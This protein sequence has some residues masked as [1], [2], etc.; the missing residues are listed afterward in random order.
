MISDKSYSYV[1]NIGYKQQT[2]KKK[3][4]YSTWQFVHN[5][6]QAKVFQLLQLQIVANTMAIPTQLGN[7]QISDNDLV[8]QHLD[9]GLFSFHKSY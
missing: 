5:N 4:Q 2:E 9:V 3:R 6:L 1:T 7:L 8:T